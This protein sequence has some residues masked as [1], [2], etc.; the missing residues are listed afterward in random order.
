MKRG[1]LKILL[2]YAFAIFGTAALTMVML[3][4]GN[5]FNPT[6]VALIFLLFVLFLATVFTSNPALVASVLAMLCFNYFFLP[7]V[8][9][10]R[11]ADPENWIALFAFLVVAVT[12]GQL[13][14]K[15]RH[16]AEEAERLYHE[17]QGAFEKA[18]QTEALK[19]SE[20]LKS[21]LLDA[22]TH[23]LRTPLTSIKA[24]ATTL[25]EDLK[26]KLNEQ[27]KTD[28][29]SIQLDDEAR[30]EFVE[31]INEESDR[32]NKFIGG[33][34]SLAKV[35]AGALHLRKSW[36]KVEEII[37]DAVERAKMRLDSHYI[38]IEIEREL[39]VISVDANSI[40]EVVYTLLDNAAKY[41]LP[42]SK[43]R[44][45]ANRAANETIEIAVEDCGRGVSAEMREKVFD[46]FFRAAEDEIHTTSSG[47]GFPLSQQSTYSTSNL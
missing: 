45:L 17:L 27:P 24:S 32:L 26:G 42:K 46:K 41:S 23:D 36:S 39:P 7:P 34:V 12:A 43:I 20:K 15:A 44:I 21:A 4:L 22:V 13:S 16:R 6:T 19:R 47:L 11:V 29:N 10:F 31:I 5:H 8:G 35:E 3:A 37:N 33:M 30:R 18:S 14:A 2:P 40:V 25:L 38:A 9:T 28:N 1:Y